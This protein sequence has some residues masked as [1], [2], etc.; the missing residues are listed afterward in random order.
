M[1]RLVKFFLFTIV[2]QTGISALTFLDLMKY[3]YRYKN[4]KRSDRSFRIQTLA[5]KSNCEAS[6]VVKNQDSTQTLHI[7]F[8][9]ANTKEVS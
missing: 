9:K 2:V 3:Q 8:P 5:E 7:R 1:T 6:R 4:L